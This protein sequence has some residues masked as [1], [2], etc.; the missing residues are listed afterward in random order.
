MYIIT[1]GISTIFAKPHEV[2]LKGSKA[3]ITVG[4]NPELHLS[5]AG[6]RRAA[7]KEQQKMASLYVYN[8]YIYTHIYNYLYIHI[9]N[10]YMYMYIFIYI[11]PSKKMC[12][13]F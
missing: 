9:N 1:D 7:I 6:P 10:M 3:H 5:A 13:N 12:N 2:H 8:I 11:S 4:V